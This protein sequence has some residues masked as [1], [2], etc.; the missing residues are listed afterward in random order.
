MNSEPERRLSMDELKAR[1]RTDTE[2]P[3]NPPS[4]IGQPEAPAHPAQP[5]QPIVIQCPL[6]QALTKLTQQAD[7]ICWELQTMREYLPELKFY[8]DLS[9][10]QR[11]LTEIQKSLA[12]MN[13][14]L[15]QAGKESARSAS[16]WLDWLPDFDLWAAAKWI[17]LAL[18]LT[19]A[20]LSV[21]YGVATVWSN[22]RILLP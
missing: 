22:I 7:E 21:W 5:M 2:K 19:A 20:G 12:Q 13:T 10:V 9:G 11:S 4:N 16:G 6:P 8:T 1:N 14:L 3:K 17:A 18:M 15:E